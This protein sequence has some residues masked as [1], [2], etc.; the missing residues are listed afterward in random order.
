MSTLPA[1]IRINATIKNANA[2]GVFMTVLHKGDPDRGTLYVRL[3][4][5]GG[6]VKLYQ[7]VFDGQKTQMVLHSEG[8]KV[9]P[10]I[11]HII[12]IDPDIWVV[13]VEDRTGRMWFDETF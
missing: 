8:D 3:D 12:D 9:D 5:H 6:I 11:T 13:E 1:H 7:Q 2:A 10:A 4:D